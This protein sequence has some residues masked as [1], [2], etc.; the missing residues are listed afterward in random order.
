MKA[1]RG[2]WS[3]L[4]A[5]LRAAL[6]R[7][8]GGQRRAELAARRELRDWADSELYSVWCASAAEVL[9]ALHAGQTATAAEARQ[10]LLAEIERRHPRDARAWLASDAV[11]TGEPPAF[12]LGSGGGQ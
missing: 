12:L 5:E 3:R 9:E 1:G 10:Y 2:R 11:L 4:L 6:R 8:G 7:N